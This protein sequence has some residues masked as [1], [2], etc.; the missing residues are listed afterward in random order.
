MKRKLSIVLL[1][2]FVLTGCTKDESLGILADKAQISFAIPN[3]R[4]SQMTKESIASFSVTCAICPSSS[5]F[6]SVGCGSYFFNEVIDAEVGKSSNYWPGENYNLSFFIHTPCNDGN[7]QVISN[8][9]D[10]GYP[11]YQYT[12]PADITRQADLMTANIIDHIGLSRVP[13]TITFNHMCTDVRFSVENQGVEN[14]IIKSITL[15]GVKHNG[16]LKNNTWTLTGSANSL[17]S[18]PFVLTANADIADGNT[19]D[20]TGTDK[21]FVLLPQTV[22]AGTELFIVKAVMDGIETTYTH[23]LPA[24]MSFSMGKSYTFNITLNQKMMIVDPDTDIETWTP[25]Q[26]D[27][28]NPQ[29]GFGIQDWLPA[30]E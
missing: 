27:Y 21:H 17:S 10:K 18:N 16:T 9:T 19:L 15:V 5:S 8:P 24:N 7:I 11:V 26:I 2:A 22:T 6:T 23:T 14:L 12:E 3:T 30:E 25:E 4:A 29:S 1:T 28:I 20:V 13:L